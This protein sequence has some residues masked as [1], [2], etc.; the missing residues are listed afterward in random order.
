MLKNV[1]LEL[2]MAM[3]IVKSILSKSKLKS[4]KILKSN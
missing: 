1:Q 3:K 2:V 4:Q